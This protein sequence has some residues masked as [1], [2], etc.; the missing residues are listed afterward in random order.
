[1]FFLAP[2]LALLQALLPVTARAEDWPSKPVRIVVN[3]PPGGGIDQITRVFSPRLGE[4]LAQPVI[5]DNRGGAGGNIG[6]E[7]VAK[8]PPDGYTLLAAI[9]STMVV[10]PHLYKLSFDVN[11][12]LLPV[13]PIA[14]TLMFLVV[15]PD[16]PVKSVAELVAYARAN[17]DKL[18]FGSP[19]MGTGPH[20]AAEMML[21]TARIRATHIPYKGSAETMAALFGNQVEFAFD[22]GSAVRQARAGKLRLLAVANAACPRCAHHGRGR[23]RRRCEHGARP[24]RARRHAARNRRPAAPGARP[25]H[26]HA[27]GAQ[28]GE[29]G[30]GRIGVRDARGVRRPAAPR[31][32]ALRRHRARGRHP[33]RVRCPGPGPTPVRHTL[34][35][36]MFRVFEAFEAT[37]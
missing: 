5:V 3:V 1:M 22:P 36:G 35:S 4:A 14:R 31:P 37:R 12:D 25:H 13:A 7:T 26:A 32:G 8:A 9:G 34:E 16:L 2:V 28:G 23:N 20:I 30:H 24:L 33:R 29:R 21:R 15:R 19:G 10:G 27:R 11:R 18:N 6:L 17:P